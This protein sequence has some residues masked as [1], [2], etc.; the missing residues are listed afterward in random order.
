MHERRDCPGHGCRDHKWPH[1][2]Y[3]GTVAT[4]PPVERRSPGP[5]PG[6]AVDA[7]GEPP[8]MDQLLARIENPPMPAWYAPREGPRRRVAPHEP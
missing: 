5:G 1:A 7:P 8:T 2:V 6:V 3:R 4:G